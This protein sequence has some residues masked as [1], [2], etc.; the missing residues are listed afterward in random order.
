MPTATQIV[1]DFLGDAATL[2]LDRNPS[3]PNRPAQT[4]EELV[5]RV[6]L[7]DQDIDLDVRSRISGDNSMP[8]RAWHG[9]LRQYALAS[10]K[11]GPSTLTREELVS[12]VE[13]VLPL[14]ERVLA[15]GSVEWDGSNHVGRLNDDAR[16]AGYELEELASSGDLFPEETTIQTWDAADWLEA[17][18]LAAWPDG[19]TLEQAVD[20]VEREAQDNNIVLVGQDVD[21]VLLD[22]AASAIERGV[23]LD[24]I[25]IDALLAA[26][27]IDADEAAELREAIRTDAPNRPAP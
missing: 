12:A 26:D 19:Q 5:L 3:S 15:G 9:V 27:R 20:A 18:G 14:A 2:S 23:P 7:E 4:Y 10:S 16:D 22:I 24:A 6:D 21:E 1:D 11:G 25:K 13:E 8:M 17:A